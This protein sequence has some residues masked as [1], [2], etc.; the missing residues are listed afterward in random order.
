MGVS[1]HSRNHHYSSLEVD[2]IVAFHKGT[3]FVVE[4]N[5]L[6]FQWVES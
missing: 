6:I 1:E 5:Q 4:L 3:G 2:Q